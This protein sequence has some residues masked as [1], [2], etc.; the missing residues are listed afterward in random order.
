MSQGQLVENVLAQVLAELL[1][2][3]RNKVLEQSYGVAANCVVLSW[4]LDKLT[5]YGDLHNQVGLMGRAAPHQEAISKLAQRP[6]L[7]EQH[8]QKALASV[9][10]R[11]DAI[12][13]DE[14]DDLDTRSARDIGCQ[15]I[16]TRGN[17]LRNDLVHGSRQRPPV[18]L[19][20]WLKFSENLDSRSACKHMN[21]IVLDFAVPGS[22]RHRNPLNLV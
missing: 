17:D 20:Q 21:G 3:V 4:R 1:A 16:Q 9:L 15:A 12:T 22:S 5:T 19:R 6:R 7:G 13:S 2:I 10:V 18:F 8:V 14:V 11:V